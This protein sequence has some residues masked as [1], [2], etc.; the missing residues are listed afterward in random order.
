MNAERLV[1]LLLTGSLAAYVVL[2]H[3][4]AGTP[5]LAG[6]AAVTVLLAVLDR[7]E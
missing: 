4:A 1:L 2:Q 5:L 3:P 6:L 7:E